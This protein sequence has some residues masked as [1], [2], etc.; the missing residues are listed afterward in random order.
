MEAFHLIGMSEDDGGVALTS[1][2]GMVAS[3]PCPITIDVHILQNYGKS[4]GDRY[5]MVSTECTRQL[6]IIF[7]HRVIAIDC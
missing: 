6:F 3:G 5:L 2:T 7:F 4:I 1:D